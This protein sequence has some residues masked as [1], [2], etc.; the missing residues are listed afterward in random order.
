MKNNNRGFTL[1]ELLIVVAIV[2]ILSAIALPSYQNYTIRAQVAEGLVLAGPV[3]T[4]VTNTMTGDGVA[5]ANNQAAGLGA[6]TDYYGSYVRSIS[7]N[8]GNVQILFGNQA[9]T[10]IYGNVL[11]LTLTQT[12][13][14]IRWTCSGGASLPGGYLPKSCN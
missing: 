9:H 1:I 13:S 6:A 4:A 12:D 14:Q 11:T 3:K 5:P 10:S 2:A 7:V 8:N